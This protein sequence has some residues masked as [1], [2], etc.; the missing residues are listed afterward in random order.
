MAN[1]AK[2]A[3]A[4]ATADKFGLG[5]DWDKLINLSWLEFFAFIRSLWDAFSNRPQPLLAKGADAATCA[6]TCKEHFELIQ[7]VASC[8]VDCCDC[9]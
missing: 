5:L 8:G 3:A 7:A 2:M 1:S 9:V 6:T 4:K